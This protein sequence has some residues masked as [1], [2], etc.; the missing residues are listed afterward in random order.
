MEI[1]ARTGGKLINEEVPRSYLRKKKTIDRPPIK[2][3]RLRKVD[4]D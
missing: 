1:H 2:F 3:E 4:E